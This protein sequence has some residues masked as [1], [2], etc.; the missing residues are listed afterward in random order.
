MLSNVNKRLDNYPVPN[1]SDPRREIITLIR[2]FIKVVSSHI[3]GD[4]PVASSETSLIHHLNGAYGH[5]RLAVHRTAPQFRPWDSSYQPVLLSPDTSATR[6]R[7][8][9]PSTISSAGTRSVSPVSYPS[10]PQ[11]MFLSPARPVDLAI[12]TLSPCIQD[13]IAAANEGNPPDVEGP[14]WYLNDVMEL[15]ERLVKP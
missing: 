14:I 8:P 7:S 10:P 1:Y 12:S 4:R 11:H 9:E 6:L 15:A 2:D 3:R 5:F 13:M